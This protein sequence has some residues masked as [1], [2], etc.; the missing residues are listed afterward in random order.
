MQLLHQPLHNCELWV[1][2]GHGAK[3][4]YIPGH[5]PAAILGEEASQGL[6]FM[7]AV[8]GCDSVSAFHGIGKKTAWAVWRSMPHINHVLSHL[9]KGSSIISTEDMEEIER[10]VVLLYQRTSPLCQVNEARKQMFATGNRKIENIPRTK[11]ALEQH[12][13]RAAYQAGHIWGQSLIG[14]P[15]TPSPSLLRLEKAG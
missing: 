2:F 14:L 6:L 9:E 5:R 1:A 15:Q 12:V 3:L 11:D 8:S 4:R 7:H 13:K 10:Y